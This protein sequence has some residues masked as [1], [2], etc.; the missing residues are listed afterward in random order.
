M[1]FMSEYVR[2]CWVLGRSVMRSMECVLGYFR[3]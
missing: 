2:V 3:E 1:F